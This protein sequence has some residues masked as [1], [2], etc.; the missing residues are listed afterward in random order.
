[1]GV[2]ARDSTVKVYKMKKEKEEGEKENRR[3]HP[4]QNAKSHVEQLSETDAL[5]SVAED[6]RQML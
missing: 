2:S 1:M 5:E 3:I 4:S 6:F